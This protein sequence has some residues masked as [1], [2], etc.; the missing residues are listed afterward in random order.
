[1]SKITLD[2]GTQEALARLLSKHLNA[3][4]DVDIG[5]FEALD[6][7]EFLSETLGPHYYNQ[8]LYDA[9]A[10]MKGRVDEV[11]EAVHGIEKPVKL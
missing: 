9:Q 11:L 2:K 10:I 1:M 5:Q 6:L 3:E 8:G 7:L 4:F